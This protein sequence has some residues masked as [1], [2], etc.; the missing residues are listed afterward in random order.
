[1]DQFRWDGKDF[2]EQRALP[3]GISEG[4]ILGWT[5]E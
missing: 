4:V 2:L 5:M 1:M 3:L